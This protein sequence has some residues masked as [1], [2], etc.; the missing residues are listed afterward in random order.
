MIYLF[1]RIWNQSTIYY[2]KNRYSYLQLKKK[3]ILGQSSVI[4]GHETVVWGD[5]N[6]KK[7]WI[8]PMCIRY[9]YFKQPT[10]PKNIFEDGEE[11]LFSYLLIA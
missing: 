6:N 7:K 10:P 11:I 5:W 8:R 3:N 1:Y 9:I 2:S 4:R